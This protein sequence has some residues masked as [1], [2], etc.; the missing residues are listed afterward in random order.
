MI[1]VPLIR[2][3]YFALKNQYFKLF[4]CS[5]VG[6]IGLINQYSLYSMFNK[7]IGYH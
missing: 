3:F 1:Q 2:P 6:S 5:V 7:A 4:G